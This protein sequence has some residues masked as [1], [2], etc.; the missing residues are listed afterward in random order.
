VI[1]TVDTGDISLL[2]YLLA[3]AALCGA[4]WMAYLRNGLACGLLIVVAVVA[5]ILGAD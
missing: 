2:F 4:A 5:V 1:A 3:F